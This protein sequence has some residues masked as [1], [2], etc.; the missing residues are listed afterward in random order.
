[1][2]EK[3]PEFAF[4]GVAGFSGIGVTGGWELYESLLGPML[5]EFALPRR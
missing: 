5:P 1:M 4:P 3:N 2:D